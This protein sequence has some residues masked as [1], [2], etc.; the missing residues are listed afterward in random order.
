MSKALDFRRIAILGPGLLGGSLALALQ[1]FSPD[2][3]VSLWGRRSSVIEEIR[4]R[5]MADLAS[6]DL[7]EVLQDA[8]LVILATPVGIMA[9]LCRAIQSSGVIT[10]QCVITDVG[11]VKAPVMNT[12]SEIFT[13]SE[14]ICVGSHP[15]AGSEK[16]GLDHART[17]LFSLAPCV[18]TPAAKSN[19]E[20]TVAKLELFWQ[21]IGMRTCVMDAREHDRRVARISHLPHLLASVM[22]EVAFLEGSKAASLAGTGFID[23]TRIASGAP[24]MWTEI[25]LE[26]RQAVMGELKQLQTKLGETLA[27]LEEV[28]EEGMMSFLAAAKDHRDSIGIRENR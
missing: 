8:D 28:D 19:T 20:S 6:T 26:N 9:E 24:E 2:S 21:N 22:V 16:M 11:S 14:V 4:K 3:K 5:E 27:L 18:L 1:K 7:G 23:S 25:L 13:D 10:G 12:F 15:M 17:D